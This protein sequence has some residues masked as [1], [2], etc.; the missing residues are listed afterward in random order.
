MALLHSELQFRL[1]SNQRHNHRFPKPKSETLPFFATD[2]PKISPKEQPDVQYEPDS[3]K[4]VVCND[5]LGK[6]QKFSFQFRMQLDP[7]PPFYRPT[8]GFLPALAKV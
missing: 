1:L 4:H 6:H 2:Q 8:G 7:K 3:S 5:L